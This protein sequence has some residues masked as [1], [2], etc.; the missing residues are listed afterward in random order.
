MI[1]V[2]GIRIYEPFIIPTSL[3]I[4]VRPI[5]LHDVYPREFNLL[6][7]S[8]PPSTI[9]SKYFCCVHM[10]LGDIYA[11]LFAKQ[12][13]C[14]LCSQRAFAM[15]Y[16]WYRDGCKLTL[17][18]CLYYEPYSGTAEQYHYSCAVVRS[19]VQSLFAGGRELSRQHS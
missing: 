8:I 14:G 16:R 10:N 7:L 17:R 15:N 19:H 11:L 3:L 18:L 9:V 13:L 4:N 1:L 12:L 2:C 5:S 6:G